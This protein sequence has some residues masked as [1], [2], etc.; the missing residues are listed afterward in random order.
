VTPH[1]KGT[2]TVDSL[3]LWELF[4]AV[5]FGGVLVHNLVMG[6]QDPVAERTAV[7]GLVLAMAVW[8]V[9]FGRRLVK[10][11]SAE[12]RGYVFAAGL[13][14][15]FITATALRSS[16]S[17]LLFA[18]CPLTY[19]VLP[20]RTAHAAIVA[21]SLTPAGVFIATT[22][23]LGV[24]L[25][26][27]LSIGLIAIT[28]S[29]A[30]SLTVS[31]TERLSEERA[32]LIDELA[33]SRAEVARLSREAGVAD[34]RQRLAGEI[35]DTVAQGLSSVVML[36]EAALVAEPETAKRHLELAART[37]RENL[38]EA[39]AIVGALTPAQ[40]TGAS[41]EDALRR[42]TD[43]FTAETGISSG[44]TV[45]GA[46][47]PSP[48]GVEVVLLRVVQE[49]LT[50]VRKHSGATHVDVGLSLDPSRVAV[51]V[52][53]DGSGF[54][55]AALHGG[56]GLGAMRNRVEQVGGRLSVHSVLGQGTTVRTEVDA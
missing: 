46:A 53:D 35:H 40:L 48:T 5:T 21:F 25:V 29:V 51:E 28:I 12:W 41:L 42:V 36:I 45:S 8:Y 23:E 18:L 26:L 31:R 56:Y 11:P 54:D 34:E 4:F 10:V 50:N 27:L 9:G 38:D 47:R 6:R 55:D 3:A 16:T 39:R 20:L 13:L 2:W 24:D 15:L 37:A 7:T 1:A 14:A 30:M 44:L 52:S 22:G 49:A 19:M 17:F 33:S 32:A 43:R